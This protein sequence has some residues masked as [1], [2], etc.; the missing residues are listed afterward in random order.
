LYL[1]G[2]QHS[3]HTFSV[4]EHF[5][6]KNDEKMNIC[7]FYMATLSFLQF[8]YLS[9]FLIFKGRTFLIST[10]I[11]NADLL[12][13]HSTAFLQYSRQIGQ[14]RSCFAFTFSFLNKISII[15]CME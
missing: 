13:A 9:E 15:V 14:H 11:K 6:Q 2:L 4:L 7:H 8:N 3:E 1:V 10:E 5:S 12:F